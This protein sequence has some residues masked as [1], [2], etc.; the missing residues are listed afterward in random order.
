[1]IKIEFIDVLGIRTRSTK[2]FCRTIRDASFPQCWPISRRFIHEITHLNV[3]TCVPGFEVM[4]YSGR[5]A[6][7]EILIEPNLGSHAWGN[8]NGKVA[9]FICYSSELEIL[10]AN[11]RKHCYLQGSARQKLPLKWLQQSIESLLSIL[12]VYILSAS[13]LCCGNG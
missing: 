2:L 10:I 12:L 4:V 1:M 13:L 5:G 6:S 7:K 8:N 9:V 11:N 3:T